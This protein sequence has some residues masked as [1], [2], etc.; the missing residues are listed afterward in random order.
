MTYQRR[1]A[2]RYFL[3]TLIAILQ[4]A[5]AVSAAEIWPSGVPPIVGQKMVQESASDYLDL[6]KAE[7]RRQKTSKR[8]KV[9]RPMAG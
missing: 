7:T 6:F 4:T 8:V 3:C 9:F 5:V 1:L 2:Y